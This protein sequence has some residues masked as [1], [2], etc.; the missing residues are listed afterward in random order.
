MIQRQEIQTAEVQSGEYATWHNFK[1]APTFIFLLELA[2]Q[3]A[4]DKRGFACAR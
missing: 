2:S 3:M 4:F 1:L